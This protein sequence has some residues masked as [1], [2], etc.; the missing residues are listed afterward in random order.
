[1]VSIQLYR[2]FQA[3]RILWFY[4]SSSHG[5]GLAGM[6]VLGWW[7]DLM[8]L[9]VFSNL[10]DSM[11]LWFFLTWAWFSRHAGARLTVGLDDLGGLFQ[12]LRFYDSKEW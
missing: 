6:L 1:M 12:P 2:S 4:D 10:Y 9:K 11:I 8:I 5:H 3:F 7:L